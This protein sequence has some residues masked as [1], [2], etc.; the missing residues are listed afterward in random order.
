MDIFLLRKFGLVRGYFKGSSG[1]GSSSQTV[2][3]YS[4]EEAAQRAKVQSEASRIYGST[5]GK[6]SSAPYTGAQVVPQSADTLTGQD[7]TKAAANTTAGTVIPQLLDATKFGLSDSMNVNSNP[8]LQ[9]A[10]GA[11]VRPIT[12]SYTDAGGV[13]NQIRNN[14]EVDGGQGRS[15]RQGV[16]EGI[17]AGRYANAI[18]DASARVASDGYGK[19]L[20]TFA[21]TLAITPQT[22]STLNAPGQA[23]SAIGNQ[24]EG[25]AQAAENYAGDSRNWDLNAEW[26]P[27]QNWANIVYG[28]TGPNGTTTKSS[29]GGTKSN[30]LMGA[31]G[32][33]MAG[34]QLGSIVPGIGTGIGAIGGAVLG[35]L[36]S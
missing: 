3:N 21:R 28:G 7:L 22:V 18:G 31:A 8:Y 15:T 4:P 9:S 36:F 23:Y 33:A 32:G 24:N 13:M 34:A 26:T 10:I 16:A 17:A 19:G 6:I 35:G 30:P 14:S 5:A 27:L 20:D 11:A 2:Q 1:G 25:Y 29:G 12:E